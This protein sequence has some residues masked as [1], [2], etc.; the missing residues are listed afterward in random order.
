MIPPREDAEFVYRIEDVLELYHEPYGPRHPIVCFDEVPKQLVKEKRVVLPA[1]PGKVSRFDYEYERNGVCNL[2]MV[3]EPLKGWRHV[4]VNQRRTKVDWAVCMQKLAHEFYPEA[5]CI[6]VVM[7]Q[8]NTHNPAALYKIFVP[9]EARRLLKRLEFHSTPKHGS[10]LNM[11]EI[12][13]SVLSRQ[14][15]R[16]RIPDEERL[17]REVKAWENWR[18]MLRKSTGNLPLKTH[19]L[20]LKDFIHHSIFL[21]TTRLCR[22]TKG[23]ILPLLC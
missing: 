7:D 14:C 20:S 22:E 3:F 1:K 12:E 19:A 6:R 23:G 8:L 10:W 4:E 17:R 5:E 13:L 9:F 15:L 18:P 2:F 11:A 16:R 21:N